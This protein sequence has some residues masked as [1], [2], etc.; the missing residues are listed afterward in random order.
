MVNLCTLCRLTT[1]EGSQEKLPLVGKEN[2][3]VVESEVKKLSKMGKCRSRSGKVED[4][5][6][7]GAEGDPHSQGAP[8]REEKVS[9][10][11]TVSC[12]LRSCHFC[13][14]PLVSFGDMEKSLV[15]K[16]TDYSLLT[17][18][19]LDFPAI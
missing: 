13:C 8:T 9:S 1:S 2:S 19:P 10:L 12:F 4:N 3:D 16:K 11:K 7:C 17:C 5:L 6:D 15:I 14:F 18:W